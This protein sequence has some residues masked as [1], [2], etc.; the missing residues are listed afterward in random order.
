MTTAPT[1]WFDF[2]SP[3][4]YLAHRM[5][6]G[7]E[8]RT[9]VAF[10]YVP[11]L[12]GGL[13]KLTGNQPPMLVHANVANKIAYEQRDL[14]RFVAKVGA[15]KFTFNSHFPLNTLNLMRTAAA[16]HLA[17]TLPTFVEAVFVATWESG[18]KTDDMD[19][20][21]GVLGEAGLQADDLIAAGQTQEVKDHLMA[22]TQDAADKGAFGVPSFRVNDEL[23][24][25]KDRVE[26][27]ER[28]LQ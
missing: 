27:V 1:F 10:D 8:A 24:F 15:T 28:A 23:Y 22:N 13:F 9:G 6:P 19:V 7:V 16:A 14:R 3:N 25:G 2:V 12:L 20:L 26:D 17:G 21:A 5:L 18:L 11:V 4:A